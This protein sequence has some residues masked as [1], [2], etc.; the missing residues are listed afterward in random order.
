MLAN[1]YSG[2]TLWRFRRLARLAGRLVTLHQR[3]VARIYAPGGAGFE[4]CRADFDERVRGSEGGNVDSR[5]EDG[6]QAK[7][8]RI[9]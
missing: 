3:A 4:A 6:S 7:K 5:E 2:T 9:D 8:A 1:R